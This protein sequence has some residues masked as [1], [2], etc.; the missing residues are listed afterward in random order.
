MRIMKEVYKMDE[1]QNEKLHI[2]LLGA[3]RETV[4]LKDRMSETH[5]II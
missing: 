4:V 3:W 5:H 2:S 1:K